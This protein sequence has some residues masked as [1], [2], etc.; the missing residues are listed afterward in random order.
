MIGNARMNCRMTAELSKEQ[1]NRLLVTFRS[2]ELAIWTS[3][4]KA[5]RKCGASRQ[6][7][8]SLFIFALRALLPT[9][10]YN[11]IRSM[12]ISTTGRMH[13]SLYQY[14]S[15]FTKIRVTSLMMQNR[16]R[17]SSAVFCVTTFDVANQYSFFNT[18][19]LTYRNCTR[20][21]SWEARLI[22]LPEQQ[23]PSKYRLCTETEK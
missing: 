2:C 23:K 20:A 17:L 3:R 15:L 1:Q 9:F 6:A 5:K 4:K 14:L 16:A 10:Q 8:Y 7:Y 22:S 12:E 11:K 19:F 18:H 13:G 21:S